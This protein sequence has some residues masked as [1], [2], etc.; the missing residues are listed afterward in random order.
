MKDTVAKAKEAAAKAAADAKEASAIAKKA[1][2]AAAAA[3]ATAAKAAAEAKKTKPTAADKG[4]AAAPAS[5]TTAKAKATATKT[6]KAKATATKTAASKASAKVSSPLETPSGVP[7][8]IVVRP[9]T[10]INHNKAK[11]AVPV[12]E[13]SVVAPKMARK[14]GKYPPHPTT[15]NKEN[16]SQVASNAQVDDEV[17][18]VS[19]LNIFTQ[20]ISQDGDDG[21]DGDS[22]LKNVEVPSSCPATGCWDKILA[23]DDGIRQLFK[24]YNEIIKTKGVDSG[25]AAREEVAI[26]YYIKGQIRLHEALV[27]AKQEGW[28]TNINFASLVPRVLAMKDDLHRLIFVEGLKSKNP[29]QQEFNKNLLKMYPAGDGL[30]RLSGMR[31]TPGLIA[32]TTRVG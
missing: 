12:P 18:A 20:R 25:P 10:L 24:T 7:I 31:I 21:D 4:K 17:R 23:V 22:G 30:Q 3:K 9:G 16:V 28:P 13:A 8:N 26:C 1:A 27:Y 15:S 6:A 2:A 11:Q 19:S 5:K 29:A 14:M 32:D